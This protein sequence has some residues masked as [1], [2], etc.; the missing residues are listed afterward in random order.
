MLSSRNTLGPEKFEIAG[1]ALASSINVSGATDAFSLNYRRVTDVNGNMGRCYSENYDTIGQTSVRFNYLEK[2]D[3]GWLW[4]NLDDRTNRCATQCSKQS[5][6]RAFEM[7]GF[8]SATAATLGSVDSNGWYIKCF[9]FLDGTYID[10]PRARVITTTGTV[11]YPTGIKSNDYETNTG[12]R[13][14]ER[15]ESKVQQRVLLPAAFEYNTEYTFLIK[16]W[17]TMAAARRGTLQSGHMDTRDVLGSILPARRANLAGRRRRGPLR[18]DQLDRAQQSWADYR[19]IPVLD[20][21]HL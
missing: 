21:P 15:R 7:Y 13:C 4:Y 9:G 8:T 5:D 12:R 20:L 18:Q 1:S 19:P 2:R 17:N 16:P 10:D 14:F 6:C 11:K 3:L